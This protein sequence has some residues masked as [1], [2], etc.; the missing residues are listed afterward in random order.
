MTSA[1]FKILCE[2]CQKWLPGLRSD[3]D[4]RS[5]TWVMSCDAHFCSAD[6]DSDSLPVSTGVGIPGFDLLASHTCL[7]TKKKGG[8]QAFFTKQNA[9]LKSDLCRGKSNFFVPALAEYA[10]FA[11]RAVVDNKHPSV[12]V[13]SC[14]NPNP[15]V[16]LLLTINSFPTRV[17]SCSKTQTYYLTNMNTFWKNPEKFQNVVVGGSCRASQLS[18]QLL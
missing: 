16:V 6:K 7:R 5:M 18:V 9:D 8:G 15:N 13:I 12:C 14:K 1:C 4:H 3:D 2:T 10:V 11:H 17:E